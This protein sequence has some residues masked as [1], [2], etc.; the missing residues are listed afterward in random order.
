MLPD[1]DSLVTVP[2]YRYWQATYRE[3]LAGYLQ[4]LAETPRLVWFPHISSAQELGS[5]QIG[6]ENHIT[7]PREK[8]LSVSM[9]MDNCIMAIV[10]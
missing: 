1:F 9:P 5:F 6:C 8:N 7:F 2:R 10:R 4:T 3:A